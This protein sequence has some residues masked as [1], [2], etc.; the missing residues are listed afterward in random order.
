MTRNWIYHCLSIIMKHFPKI[1]LFVLVCMFAVPQKGRTQSAMKESILIHL[2]QGPENPTVAALAF[3]VAKT[4]VED[5]HEVTLFLAGD[6]VQLM[7]AEAI[8][9]VTGLGTG[10]LKSHYEV[11]EKAGC[12]FY[13][14]GM[15]SKS[16]GLF[17]E[18]LQG[19]KVKFAM[20]A[21]L[22]KLSLDNDRMFVY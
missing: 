13:L 6:A 8:E 5:G 19:K 12:Q 10:S 14:S 21:E 15:S 20:P 16:R 3:L 22:L 17:L 1:Y 9:N 4:A 18:Q 7:R 2:T 11:L